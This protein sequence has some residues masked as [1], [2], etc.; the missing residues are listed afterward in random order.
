MEKLQ[1]L[2]GFTLVSESSS[3]LKDMVDYFVPPEY[4]QNLVQ[5]AP[6]KDPQ[7]AL[8][9]LLLDLFPDKVVVMD[10]NRLFQHYL[11]RAAEKLEKRLVIKEADDPELI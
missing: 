2:V 7:T 6:S 4:S 3:I 10:H 1:Q 11:E 8:T 5:Y 9:L